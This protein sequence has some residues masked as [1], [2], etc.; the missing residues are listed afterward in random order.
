[1]ETFVRDGLIFDVTERGPTGG[2]VVILLHGFPGGSE[3]WDTVSRILANDGY[4]VLVPTQRGYAPK[5]RPTPVKDYRLSELVGDILALCDAAQAS[6]VHLVGHDWGGS[7]GWAMAGTCSDRLHSLTIISMPHPAAYVKS[8]V[9]SRQP[10]LSWYVIFFLIPL[11]PESLILAKNGSVGRRWL[12]RMGLTSSFA[13]RYI[14]RYLTDKGGLRGAVNWYRAIPYEIFDRRLVASINVRTLYVWGS[15]D[16]A[17]SE[18][19]AR[20][21][22]QHVTDTFR[23][24]TLERGTHW[25]PEDHP[26]ELSLLIRDWIGKQ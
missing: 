14:S 12:E 6:K 9:S 23:F 7:V 4:R 17:I 11:V 18:R 22:R 16:S 13:D 19:A 21:T 8:L 5:A 1:M 10:L 15:D 26:R 25:I 2:E 3:T 24:E 20:L